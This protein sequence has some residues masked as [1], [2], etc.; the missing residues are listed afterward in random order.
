[1]KLLLQVI[2]LVPSYRE[3]TRYLHLAVHQEDIADLRRRIA[4]VV[5]TQNIS[6]AVSQLDCQMREQV[7]AI[8][9]AQLLQRLTELL[10]WR[11]STLSCMIIY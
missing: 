9:R 6:E 10:V 2:L 5:E 1:M 3:A 7:A 11:L 8:L 4:E